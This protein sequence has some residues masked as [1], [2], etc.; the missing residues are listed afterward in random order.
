MEDDFLNSKM[1]WYFRRK[2]KSSQSWIWPQW[3][4]EDEMTLTCSYMNL[5]YGRRR[6]WIS[7]LKR[8]IKFGEDKQKIL[9]DLWGLLLFAFVNDLALRLFL[10]F[11]NLF[12][13]RSVA[14]VAP[15]MIFVLL[16]SLSMISFPLNRNS[17]SL[18]LM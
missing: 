7:K 3:E 18:H 1:S 12:L 11:S 13:V 6:F 15:A 14:F 2:C 10:C 4:N 16:P 9:Y 8:R 17:T 5:W